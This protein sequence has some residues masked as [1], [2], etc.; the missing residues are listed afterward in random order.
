MKKLI[1]PAITAIFIELSFLLL[2]AM[3]SFAEGGKHL[4]AV[5]WEILATIFIIAFPLIVKTYYD[6]E[7]EEN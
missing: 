4:T 2:I 6:I 3:L 7:K 5:E 1:N